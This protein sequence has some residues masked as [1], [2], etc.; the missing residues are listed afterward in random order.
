VYWGG[1]VSYSI[2][3]KEKLLAV[4]PAVIG[5]FGVVSR[6]TAEAMAAGALGASR[7]DI[8]VAVTG[9]AGPGGGTDAV[10][11]GTVCIAAA[12]RENDGIAVLD[13]VSVRFAGPRSRVR[14]RTVR[15]ALAL[16][17]AHLD[18]E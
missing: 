15:K 16:V 9:V 2:E 4:D 18:R 12:R 3:A 8:S 17:L 13:S 6:E 5:K 14:S 10:P 1:F 11:V 7:A